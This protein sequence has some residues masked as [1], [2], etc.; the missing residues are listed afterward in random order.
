MTDTLI[1]IEN[2]S[3][4]FGGLKAVDRV[5]FLQQR[6]M[7]KAIIGPN[8]AGKT[9]LFNLIAGSLR[10]TSGKVFLGEREITSCPDYYMPRLGLARTFQN[11]R[12]F[13]NMTVLENAMLGL[14]SR[15]RAGFIST[16][17]RLPTMLNEERTIRQRAMEALEFVGLQDAWN[18][19]SDRLPFKHQRLLEF[20]RALAIKP[21]LIL[22][23]EPAAGLNS[24]ETREIAALIKKIHK[25]GVSILLVE[26][27]MSLVMDISEEIL[28][29]DFGKK[30]AE[31]IPSE[32][33]DNQDVINIYLGRRAHNA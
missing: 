9:T 14:H 17:L 27:D 10:P 15:S 19:P 31:G 22:A 29:L 3:K 24:R 28:V 21:C 16:T 20:A 30:I 5:S 23:D 6:G 32:I 12:I 33:R 1:K 7:I 13:T 2:L 25:V 18:E 26:H 11:T 4:H 8:G